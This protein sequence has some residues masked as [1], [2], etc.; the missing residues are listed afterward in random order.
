MRL[1]RGIRA[2]AVIAAAVGTLAVSAVLG[3]GSL[4]LV[5]RIAHTSVDA[6]LRAHIDD[7]AAQVSEDDGSLDQVDLEPADG[8]SPVYVTIS[9]P[10]GTVIATTPGTPAGIDPCRA[11]A[12]MASSVRE[13]STT[14][15][16]A[17]VCATTSLASVEQARSQVV[18]I[19]AVV[20]PLAILGV[21]AAVW[22]AVGR[23]LRA[24]EGLR[25]QAERMTGT[26]DGLL[27]VVPTGDEVEQLGRTLNG[28]LARLHA[29]SRATRQ[30]VADAGHELRNPL[31]TLRVALEFEHGDDA[32]PSLA[33][34]E[35]D[36]LEGLV[37]D[38][39]A[40]ARTDARDQPT[41]API[42]VTVVAADAARASRQLD[43]AL[44]LD[45]PP[46]PL[47]IAGDERS[48][49]GA[50]DNLL[51]N[52]RRHR[53]SLVRLRVAQDGPSAV[54]TVDDDGAGLRPE[55]VERVF[56]RFVRL[57]ESRVRDEGGSGLGL[58]IVR[59]TAIAHGGQAWAE[60][61]PGGHFV[62][63][64]PLHSG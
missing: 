49:R 21:S 4:L 64:L 54:I 35:L 50:I 36:R 44:E 42:D 31:A 43:A 57:D 52:A 16:V 7:A 38:L 20:L 61:G 9:Q 22:L 33:L 19:L 62:L 15:G 6:V 63:R 11:S 10:P 53:R 32:E 13:V 56:E 2:R 34:E 28:L 37:Q 25:T 39:L 12:D 59:A 29:Q 24:V 1:Q 46:G 5:M 41:F 3:L 18:R 60:P 51:R 26:D 27:E 17:T 8:S 47:I 23:A 55:D 48:L 30:F 14:T 45:L 40:L 58:A